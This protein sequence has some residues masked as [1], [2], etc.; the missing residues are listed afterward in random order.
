MTPNPA[1]MS[2]TRWTAVVARTCALP[3]P[4]ASSLAA[5]P[6]E[7]RTIGE[8]VAVTARRSSVPALCTKVPAFVTVP[9]SVVVPAPTN[10]SALVA[11]TV[12]IVAPGRFVMTPAEPGQTWRL[13]FERS[14]PAFSSGLTRRG[15]VVTVPVSSIT[16]SLVVALE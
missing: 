14:V 4:E 6:G 11:P 7:L 2:A 15:T 12:V 9:F 3:V 8:P 10:T 13:R 5:M 1:A 16:P